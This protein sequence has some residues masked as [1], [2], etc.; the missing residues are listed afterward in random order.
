MYCVYNFVFL[1][2]DY[3]YIENIGYIFELFLYKKRLFIRIYG[4]KN[5]IKMFKKI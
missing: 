4:V 1:I 3:I 5:G 2:V